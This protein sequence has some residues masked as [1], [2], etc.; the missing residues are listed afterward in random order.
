MY[1]RL[2]CHTA[3]DIQGF[4]IFLEE[5]CHAVSYVMI[6]H[7][8]LQSAPFGLENPNTHQWQLSRTPWQDQLLDHQPLVL[9]LLPRKTQLLPVALKYNE[10]I[11]TPTKLTNIASK[12]NVSLSTL[13][14][15][16]KEEWTERAILTQSNQRGR[17]QWLKESKEKMIVH[18]VLYSRNNSTPLDRNC[19]AIMVRN[20][21]GTSS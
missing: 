3:R 9:F 12:K 19:L 13:H 2:F 15:E 11:E 14:R 5:T 21:V 7:L 18:V 8:S 10:K 17:K 20:L 1:I 16:I 6:T 4:G